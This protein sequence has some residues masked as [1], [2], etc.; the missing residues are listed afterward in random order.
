MATLS[1]LSR[2]NQT[3]ICRNPAVSHFIVSPTKCVTG[4]RGRLSIDDQLAAIGKRCAVAEELSGTRHLPEQD[5]GT[6]RLSRPNF[7]IAR[8]PT[9]AH[10][11]FR[12]QES[13]TARSGNRSLSHRRKLSR[14]QPNDVCSFQCLLSLFQLDYFL[15]LRILAKSLPIFLR[16]LPTF[17]GQ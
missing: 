17:V 14:A 13:A 10:R 1:Q 11:P 3:A 12:K 4:S 15:K 9:I 5:F 2:F 8:D 6:A 16:F 7:R